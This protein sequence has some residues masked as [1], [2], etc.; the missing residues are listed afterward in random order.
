M[1]QAAT[2][3]GLGLPCSPKQALALYQHLFRCPAGLGQLWA[4]LQ[5]VRVTGHRLR[6]DRLSVGSD[7]TLPPQVGDGRT[8]PSGLEL[9]TVLL[10]MERSRRAQEQLLWDLELLTGAGLGLS[11]PPWAQFCGLRDRAQCAWSQ[12]SKPR[13]RTDGGSERRTSGN[14]RLCP[15]P[16]AEDSLSQDHQLL[17]GGLAKDP[18][19]ALDLTEARFDADP[20]WES[21]GM[22]A[23][24]PTSGCSQELNLTTS[25]SFGEPGSSEFKELAQ[26]E[27]GELARPMP[28]GPHQPPSRSLQEKKLAQGAP[29]PSG[30]PSQGLPEPPDPLEGLGCSLG[31]E[32][33]ELKKLL[34]SEIPQSQREGAP[35][36]QRGKAL[37]GEDKEVPP[38]K[39][40]KTNDGQSGEAPQALREEVSEGQRWEASQGE[41]KEAPRSQSGSR[42]KCRRK[43]VLP[44]Q[45]EDSPQG[46][47]VK[48]LQ[49]SEGRGRISQAW[50]VARGEAPTPPR[51]EGGS[52]G[53]P[54]GFCRP[55]GERMPQPGGR[56]GPDP[57]GRTTQL[58]QV[59]TGGPRGES[60]AAVREQGPAREEAPA[61]L[62]PPGPPARPPLPRPGAVL[63]AALRTGGSEQ[64]ER[65]AA[66]PGHPGL[67]SDPHSLRGPGGS[68]GPAEQELGGSMGLPGALGG[69]REGAEAPRALKT[70]WPESPSRDR[71][72]A[73][74][75]AAQQET[76][77]QRLLELHSEARR[78]RQQD[79][80][81]Q[82]LRVLERLRIARNRHC[83]VYP[84]RPPPSPAQL[85][86]QARPLGEG[87]GAAKTLPGRGTGRDLGPFHLRAPRTCDDTCGAGGAGLPGC[88]PLL[89]ASSPG[90][91]R[92]GRSA[93]GAAPGGRGRAAERPAGAAEANATGEDRAAASPRGQEHPE[94]PATSVAPWL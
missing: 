47:E 56:E 1:E 59:K 40:E 38:R 90:A 91:G 63:L 66:L 31:Q 68:P 52:L 53:I 27:D 92:R 23:E 30:L 28:Q 44:E 79:R 61:P 86:R 41:N 12:C 17:E 18:S 32:R 57:R 67:L 7:S 8:C 94:L 5:Q 9:P 82:R 70:T 77:L 16:Q 81:Q 80:E 75:S 42:L 46:P 25:S 51:E 64:R 58:R 88:C 2:P 14:S 24:G 72:S 48:T 36:D 83:R 11:W 13:G 62:T 6:G 10:Q 89:A 74:V 20:R 65:P 3:G 22:P 60:A 69:R 19:S 78:R 33:A 15:S 55:L 54:G 50:E 37:Q 73:S 21:P 71:R 29:G 85:P 49:P 43:E 4:A 76:A 87:G 93:L 45:N 35:Q 34:R 26:R 39:R 84:L